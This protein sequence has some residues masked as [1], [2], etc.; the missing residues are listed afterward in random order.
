MAPAVRTER[1]SYQ[2]GPLAP[3]AG[4]WA[5]WID[6]WPWD[7]FATFTFKDDVSPDVALRLLDRWLGRLR[8][9][10][11]DSAAPMLQCVVAIEWTCRGRVHLHAVCRAP[12]LC[13]VSRKRWRQRWEGLSRV[14]GMARIHPASGRASGYLSKYCGKGGVIVA[15]GRFA[16]RTPPGE[17]TAHTDPTGRK[18]RDGQPRVPGL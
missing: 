5:E 7:W 3:L 6:L 2:G 11:T 18:S 14:C 9:A 16:G 15:R 8:E 17:A 13:D 10:L 4:A 1:E 12:G